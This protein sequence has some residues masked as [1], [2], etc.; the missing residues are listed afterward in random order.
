MGM[1]DSSLRQATDAEVRNA[2]R[3]AQAGDL[4]FECAGSGAEN[5]E[6]MGGVVRLP[7]GIAL[8][9]QIERVLGLGR[10]YSFW[11][12]SPAAPSR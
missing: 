6:V 1:S 8:P 9:V 7:G 12:G 11:S 3:D 5:D 4:P 2:L 10:S